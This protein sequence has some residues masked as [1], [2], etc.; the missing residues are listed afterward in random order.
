[1]SLQVKRLPEILLSTSPSGDKP[2]ASGGSR[3]DGVKPGRRGGDSKMTVRA[4]FAIPVS[5]LP[6]ASEISAPSLFLPSVA[7]FPAQKHSQRREHYE[8]PSWGQLGP[9]LFFQRKLS[10]EDKHFP[11]ESH[12]GGHQGALRKPRHPAS[13]LLLRLMKWCSPFPGPWGPSPLCPMVPQIVM[14]L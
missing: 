8:L 7:H 14:L 13:H 3:A 1:M 11:A 6:V 2:G 12:E 5:G 10:S 4:L 9:L